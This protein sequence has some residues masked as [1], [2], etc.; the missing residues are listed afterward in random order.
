MSI[1]SDLKSYA[2]TAVTEGKKYL[3]SA[4]AQLN[5]VTGQ[6]NDYVAKARENVADIADKAGEAVNELR[7]SAEKAIN[8][9]AIK[10]A[11]EPYLNRVKGYQASVTERAEDLYNG[12][13]DDPRV[14]KIVDTATPVVETVVGR[15]KPV[16]DPVIARFVKPAVEVTKPAAAKKPS[17]A[18]ATKPAATKP[19][20]KAKPA[21][22]PAARKAPA[23]RATK[24]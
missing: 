3:D 18:K 2:D 1:T 14:A 13:K 12:V 5:D 11:I 8:L 9:D 22:K 15:V 7:A 4:Q 24:A 16:V 17:P 23:K 20:A 21:T 10:T 6:A 19:V